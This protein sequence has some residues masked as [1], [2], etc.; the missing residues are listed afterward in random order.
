MDRLNQKNA[1]TD[2][3]DVDLCY[4][5]SSHRRRRCLKSSVL[6]STTATVA[7]L[8]ILSS[9]RLS[10]IFPDFQYRQN[11]WNILKMLALVFE[12]VNESEE[13]RMD[14]AAGFNVNLRRTRYTLSTRLRS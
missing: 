9:K 10:N 11:I 6:D 3:V 7:S 8:G 13:R 12:Q 4:H 2:D 5:F 14:V 1:E